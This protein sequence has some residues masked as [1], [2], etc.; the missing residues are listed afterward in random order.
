MQRTL[1]IYGNQQLG[2]S[3]ANAVCSKEMDRL[4]AECQKRKEFKHIEIANKIERIRQTYRIVS[5]PK[6]KVNFEV[7]MGMII[8]LPE[9]VSNIVKLRP[10][11][12]RRGASHCRMRGGAA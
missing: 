8:C 7:F 3:I 2:D 10:A 6:I 9:C 4:K 5:E 1:V 12:K 11:A